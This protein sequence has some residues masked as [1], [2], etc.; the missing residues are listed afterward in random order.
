M[1][2][3]IRKKN[4]KRSSELVAYKY[5][6]DKSDHFFIETIFVQFVLIIF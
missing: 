2:M 3:I 6:N 1:R 4:R 5:L